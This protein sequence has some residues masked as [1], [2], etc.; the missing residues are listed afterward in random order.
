MR[1]SERGFT[2]LEV[3]GAVALLAFVYTT[4][5]TVTIRGLRSEGESRRL[6][7]A[8]LL[9]D[10]TLAEIELQVV[11]GT[12]PELGSEESEDGIFRV[13]IEVNVFE[14]PIGDLAADGGGGPGAAAPGP[15]TLLTGA[16]SPIREILVAVRW[17][18]GVETAEVIRT[19][20]AVDPVAAEAAALRLGASG[21][22]AGTQ[23]AAGNASGALSGDPSGAAGALDPTLGTAGNLELPR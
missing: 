10:W 9:A 8:S 22:A 19:T 21:L 2:L 3:L 15:E 23:D 1:R 6:L 14:V 4:L 16:D 12:V 13:S 11:D 7:E 17:D 20:Y 18:E 5:S